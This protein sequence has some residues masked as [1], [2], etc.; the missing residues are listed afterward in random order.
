[1]PVER[2]KLAVH[3]GLIGDGVTGIQPLF[4]DSAKLGT[5]KSRKRP[6]TNGFGDAERGDNRLDVGIQDVPVC[7]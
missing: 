6:V 5:G 1:M 2:F 4:F 3:A 7:F